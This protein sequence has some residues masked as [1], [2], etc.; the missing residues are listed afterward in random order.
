[1]GT[2]VAKQVVRDDLPDVAGGAATPRYSA[3]VRDPLGEGV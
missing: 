2:I 3:T 1:M